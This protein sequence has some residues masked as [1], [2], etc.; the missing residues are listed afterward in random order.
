MKH[1][2]VSHSHFYPAFCA[3]NKKENFFHL[4]YSLMRVAVGMS[5]GVDSSV[6]ALLMKELAEEV[7]GVTLRFHQVVC[8][9][10]LFDTPSPS[11]PSTRAQPVGKSKSLISLPPLS[12][13][14]TQPPISL[15]TFKD[16]DKLPTFE[17]IR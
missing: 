16:F 9:I 11:D 12:T 14:T 2:A 15:K 10:R 6:C 17:S 1:N 13:T 5:G 4:N 3:I 8:S 7:I